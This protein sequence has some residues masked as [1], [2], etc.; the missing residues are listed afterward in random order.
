MIDHDDLPIF[1]YV[2]DMTGVCV[3]CGR[4][5]REGATVTRV[6]VA[7]ANC[8]KNGW[9]HYHLDCWADYQELLKASATQGESP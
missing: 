3:G 6:G 1:T 9:Q 4:I 2:S 8:G 5:F 7:R